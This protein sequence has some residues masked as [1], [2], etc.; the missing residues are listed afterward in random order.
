MNKPA[1]NTKWFKWEITPGNVISWLVIIG[2][3]T[4]T[5][6]KLD[7]RVDENT[8]VIAKLEAADVIT[9]TRLDAQRDISGNRQE[10]IIARLTKIETLLDERVKV[11]RK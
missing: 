7:A 9:Q 10:A 8:R 1:E 2:G 3:M 6:S 11:L 4:A 5:Y